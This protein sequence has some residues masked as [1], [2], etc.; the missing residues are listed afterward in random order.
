M[1]MRSPSR[2]VNDPRWARGSLDL[3]DEQVRDA[4]AARDHRPGLPE[5]L[6][7]RGRARS[8]SA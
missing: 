4:L 7:A 6:G 5:V 1:P 8:D 3:H 2:S